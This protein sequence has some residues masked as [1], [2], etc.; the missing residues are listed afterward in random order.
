MPS[1]PKIKVPRDKKYLMWLKDQPCLIKGCSEPQDTVIY[2]HMINE[3][4]GIKCSDYLT[5]P[6]C[7]KH[8]LGSEAV[9]SGR[10]RFEK[11][12]GVNLQVEAE[13]YYKLSKR[14]GGNE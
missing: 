14:G 6:L 8:H 3:G 5:V 10:E 7:Y 4:V 13:K 2:H 1:Y 12:H 9:H 11:R